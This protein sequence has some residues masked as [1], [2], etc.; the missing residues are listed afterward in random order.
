MADDRT[1]AF[2]TEAAAR[3]GWHRRVRLGWLGQC[4]DSGCGLPT[5]IGW[6]S[7]FPQTTTLAGPCSAW[8]ADA[9]GWWQVEVAEAGPGTDYAFSI[10]GGD[11]LPDPRSAWQPHGVHGASRVFDPRA[12]RL[13]RRGLVR[14]AR[15]ARASWERS[16]TSCTSGPSPPT[17]TLDSAVERLGHLVDLGV[18]V[19]ELM[20]LG[21]F[22]GRWGW[23]YDGAHPGAVHE[24]YGGPAALQRFVDAA[25][26]LGPRRLPGRGR[27][28]PRAERQLPVRVRAVLHRAG[29]DAMGA[30]GQPGRSGQPGGAPLDPGPGPEL[31]RRLPPRRA[32]AGRGA[33][34]ARHVGP[35]AAGPAVRRDGR[36]GGPAGPA[37]GAGRRDR[38]QRPSH[39]RA[40]H[41][42]RPGDDCAVG[43]RRPPRPARRPHR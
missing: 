5:P 42:R 10:D 39:H 28:P 18:D 22:P 33:R 8:R 6:T 21:A 11:P 36:L 37:A 43:R 29:R 26:G 2:V 1:V 14:T 15:R 32:A 24:G 13:V 4:I 3:P 31:V 27:E 20:P 9:G 16:S 35:A 41:R 23:G 25:H 19:V 17:G 40:D 38:P 30:G 7:S 12:A 34:A